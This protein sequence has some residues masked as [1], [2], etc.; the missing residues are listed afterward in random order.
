[1]DIC[2]ILNCTVGITGNREYNFAILWDPERNIKNNVNSKLTQSHVNAKQ[3][4]F[5][6][7]KGIS[8]LTRKT[9]IDFKFLEM[10][11]TLNLKNIH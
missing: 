7:A 8:D 5:C 11:P 6:A 9:S 2:T 10:E 4:M 1:M 3:L